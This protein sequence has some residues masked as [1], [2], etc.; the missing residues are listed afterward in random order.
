MS[1]VDTKVDLKECGEIR[2]QVVGIL[3]ELGHQLE[4]VIAEKEVYQQSNRHLQGTSKLFNT[5]DRWQLSVA[6]VVNGAEL[7]RLHDPRLTKDAKKALCHPVCRKKITPKRKPTK[8]PPIPPIRP[9]RVQEILISNIPMVMFVN[10]EVEE[11]DSSEVE[12]LSENESS[13]P[14]TT[15]RH[16]RRSSSIFGAP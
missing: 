4:T 16:T 13:T 3:R 7:T 6:R 9:I 8:H 15:P 12:R 1:L 11:S 5:T 10:P 2:D 14:H